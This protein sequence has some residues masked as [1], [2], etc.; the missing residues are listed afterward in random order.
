[1]A[2]PP[3][4][5]HFLLFFHL[6]LHSY[7]CMND[8][9]DLNAATF[10]RICSANHE[11]HCDYRLTIYNCIESGPFYYITFVGLVWSSVVS[12]I[13]K[14]YYGVLT[15]PFLNYMFAVGIFLLAWRVLMQKQH[16]FEIRHKLP[17]P[18]PIESMCFFGIVFNLGK[19]FRAIVFTIHL[20]R[21]PLFEQCGSSMRL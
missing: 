17:R 14:F 3:R 2:S 6:P 7:T 20:T 4:H 15:E 9:S 1:M 16:L 19:G 21:T 8:P 12:A 18:K 10:W 11:C 13:G 5:F